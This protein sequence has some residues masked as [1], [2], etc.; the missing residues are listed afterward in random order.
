MLRTLSIPTNPASTTQTLARAK[1]TTL[2]NAWK[3]LL[4]DDQREAWNQASPPK[5][6]TVGHSTYIKQTGQAYF[7][8]INRVLLGAGASMIIHPPIGTIVGPLQNPVLTVDSFS[9]TIVLTFDG[10]TFTPD[11]VLQIWTTQPFT[12]GNSY[13]NIGE[14]F[15]DNYITP[16]SPLDLSADWTKA[17]GGWQ[18]ETGCVVYC[19]P[20]II[21]IYTADITGQVILQATST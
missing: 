3:T 20:Y 18:F 10:P 8:S 2:S 6:S 11:Y 4:T 5:V 17:H 15:T 7:N 19:M 1:M 13:R 21:N 12:P 9:Q 16:S 14:K